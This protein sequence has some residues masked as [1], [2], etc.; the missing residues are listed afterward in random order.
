M[1]IGTVR[2]V[3]GGTVLI[4]SIEGGA[5]D[6]RLWLLR[7]DGS[8][9]AYIDP[10]VRPVLSQPLVPGI[11][12]LQPKGK[13][14]AAQLTEVVVRPGRETVVD[15]RLRKGIACR[16]EFVMG[17]TSKPEEEYRVEIWNSADKVFDRIRRSSDD[18][19]MKCWLE[20]GQYRVV[21]V[22]ERWS[23]EARISVAK[24]VEND[25]VRVEMRAR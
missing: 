22:S 23:G 19:T 24:G 15:L 12:Q 13:G 14:I 9:K 10:R 18:P 20:P 6:V 1:D 3:R 4:R 21:A 25:T 16:F 7:S 5:D 2:L 17:D 8:W 11:Y